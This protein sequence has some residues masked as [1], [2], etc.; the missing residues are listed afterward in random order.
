MK[1]QCARSLVTLLCALIGLYF[2]YY[3]LHGDRG[4]AALARLDAQV[5]RAESDAAK[6][7][8]RREMAQHRVAGL[9]PEALDLDLLE[10][11]ARLTLNYVGGEDVVVLR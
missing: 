2:V 7:R 8:S 4:L 6:V 10:E 11:R 3:A 1:R 9:R 5:A